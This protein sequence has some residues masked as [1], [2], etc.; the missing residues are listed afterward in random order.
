MPDSMPHSTPHSMPHSTPPLTPH[1]MRRI[2]SQSQEFKLVMLRRMCTE[3]G[4]GSGLLDKRH[5]QQLVMPRLIG[6][7]EWGRLG[8]LCM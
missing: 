6:K 2:K 1:S 8:D 4:R 7:A 5:K 3:W